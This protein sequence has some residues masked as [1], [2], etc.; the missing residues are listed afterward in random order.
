MKRLNLCQLGLPILLCG[1]TA[2]AAV[3][4]LNLPQNFADTKAKLAS[5]GQANILVLGDSLS[6]RDGSY[7]PYFRELMQARYGNAGPGYQAFSL[8]TGGGLDAGWT[9]GLNAGDNAPH[10]ALD[11]LWASTTAWTTASLTPTAREIDLQYVAQ[12][13]GG[14]FQPFYWND[15]GRAVAIGTL[16][17][18]SSQ[19]NELRHWKYTLPD[20]IG[21]LAIQTYGT[22]EVTLLGA[23]NDAD[24]PGVRVHRAANGGWGVNN[25]LQRDWTFDEQLKSLE[26][27]MV[28]IWL[29]Q[30]DQGYSREGYRTAISALVD[31]VQSQAPDAEVVLI[32]TYDQGSPNL[33]RLVEAMGDVAAAEGV[34]FINMFSVA[35]NYDL[36]VH[37]G[38]TDDGVHFS[39]AGGQYVASLLY[40]AFESDGRSPRWSG[41]IRSPFDY[42][43]PEVLVPEPSGLLI[44]AL[45]AMFM[46]RRRRGAPTDGS[47]RSTH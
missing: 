2:E 12:P 13:G 47:A 1:I 17:S 25:F 21:A 33:P 7:L 6:F 10:R 23:N 42:R 44:C 31:R 32:G 8:W 22:G 20:H 34:G 40:D 43:L 5:G 19:A 37:N 38:F 36:F 45:V 24:T 11:G 29:G 39:P 16:I 15:Q 35:G 4:S 26:T 3:P 28:M 30:N 18:S 14:A 46:S 27:D 41:R 9:M